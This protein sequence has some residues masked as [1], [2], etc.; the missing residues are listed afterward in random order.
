MTG[1][2]QLLPVRAGSMQRRLARRRSTAGRRAGSPP[3]DAVARPGGARRPARCAAARPRAPGAG[4]A[5]AVN[6]PYAVISVSAQLGVD[7]L[8]RRPRQV[9]RASTLTSRTPPSSTP[10]RRGART[11][12]STRR[13][14]SASHGAAASSRRR[15]VDRR[16]PTQPTRADRADR[17]RSARDRTHGR[18]TCRTPSSWQP[19][20][21]EESVDDDV[22]RPIAPGPVGR[23]TSTSTSGSTARGTRRSS[24]PSSTSTAGEVLAIV[25]ESGS[26][27]STDGDG[28][29]RAA[30]EERLGARLDQAATGKELVG[31]D[32]LHAAPDPRRRGRR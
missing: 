6:R 7:G 20:G 27:K 12:P 30:A 13:P 2:A 16:R 23:A 9:D 28:D 1:V 15:A 19:P 21:R 25:G 26:G 22:T 29:A 3:A 10:R 32:R 5:Q 4:A 18:N 11:A 31:I 8:D 24:T 14:T 17:P